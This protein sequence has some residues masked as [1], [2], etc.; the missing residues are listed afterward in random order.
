MPTITLLRR[1]R[2]WV[3]P[4][5]RLVAEVPRQCPEVRRAVSRRIKDLIGLVERQLPDW[6]KK[7]AHEKSMGVVSTLVGA[8]MLARAVDDAELSKAIRKAAR[9][10]VSKAGE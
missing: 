2:V 9:E 5:R 3:A 7:A 8:L 1:S 4:S 6:G 10:L